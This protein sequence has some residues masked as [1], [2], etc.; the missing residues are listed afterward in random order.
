MNKQP[1]EGA[2][3]AVL[4]APV[5]GNLPTKADEPQLDYVFILI[6]N[7]S[8]RRYYKDSKVFVQQS[9]EGADNQRALRGPQPQ[10]MSTT[11]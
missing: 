9:Q 7:E 6:S 2:A 8:F 4:S 10:G 1:V 11:P 3:L 5:G